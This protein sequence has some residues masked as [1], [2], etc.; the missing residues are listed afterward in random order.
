MRVILIY[1]NLIGE[2]GETLFSNYFDILFKTGNKHY[3]SIVKNTKVEIKTSTKGKFVVKLIQHKYLQEHCCY[4][5][6][7]YPN[8]ETYSIDYYFVKAIDFS[9]GLR[10]NVLSTNIMLSKVKKLSQIHFHLGMDKEQFLILT[11]YLL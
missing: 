9:V 6:F 1:S 10:K 11:D 8:K 7:V 2:L 4:Y 5:C 3:D